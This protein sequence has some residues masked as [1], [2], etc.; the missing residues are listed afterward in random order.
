VA[1][2]TTLWN[3]LALDPGTCDLVGASDF[4]STEDYFAAF[5]VTGDLVT[6]PEPAGCAAASAVLSG[7]V[8]LRRR[9][10]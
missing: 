5:P 1:A 6:V 7:L 3:G 9:A 10:R 4:T 8:L 2:V